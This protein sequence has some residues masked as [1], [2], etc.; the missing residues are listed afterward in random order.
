[1]TER[2]KWDTVLKEIMRRIV[3]FLKIE[4]DKYQIETLL[5]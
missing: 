4:G 2:N 1:M 5:V 3:P